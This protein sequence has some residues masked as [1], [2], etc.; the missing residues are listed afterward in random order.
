MSAAQIDDP[1]SLVN[2]ICFKEPLAPWTAAL[3]SGER[4]SLDRVFD[5]FAA[6]ASRHRFLVVEGIG[7]L[8]VPMTAHKTLA[9][10]AKRLGLPLVVV[11]RPDLGTLNHT[12]LT[13]ECARSRRIAVRAVIVNH[14][15]PPARD[16]MA[17]L[18]QRTNP[19]VLARLACAPV[20]GELPFRRE[21]MQRDYHAHPT[22]GAWISRHI[23]VRRII[24]TSKGLW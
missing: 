11:V 13:L 15:R 21:P 17:R 10:L 9:D 23:A 19:Q 6:L 24:D 20:F 22:L 5:A 8:L 12:L 1:W 16:A 3:R 4:I 14:T 18:A 2:P 7:G